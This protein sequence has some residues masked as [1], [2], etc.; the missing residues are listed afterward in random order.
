VGTPT[1]VRLRI[2]VIG[3]GIIGLACAEE[4]L[5][6]GHDVRVFDPD[7]ARGATYAAAGMLAPGG[8]AWFGEQDLLRL[9]LESLDRWRDY[10][11]RLGVD[12]RDTG[13]V[14]VGGDRGD[15][16]RLL[17]G[18]DLLVAHGV[19]VRPLGRSELRELEPTLG[20]RVVGGALLPG[21]H[22]VDPR[23]VAGELLR[24][25]GPALVRDTA[26]PRPGET[27]TGVVTGAGASYDAD[28]VVVATGHRLDA[29]VPQGGLVRPVRGEILRVRTTD[30]PTR[31]V[32]ALV[33]G[34]PVYL[35]PRAHGEVV[36][37]ATS[38]EHPGRTPD[39]P[40][41]RGVA[42]LIEAARR[43][44]PTLEDAELLEVTARDRPGSPD[45]GPLIG[46]TGVPGLL[47]ASGHFRGGV[48]LAP[49]TAEVVRAHVE[50]RAVTG[51]AAA[52]TPDRF[53]TH[54]PERTA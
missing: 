50:G 47:V 51:A 29:R 22:S 6:G 3:A 46:P 34:V 27:C 30:P 5:R 16:D 41:L 31:T 13:T 23:A 18:T 14:L 38:E 12:Y 28:A 17:S 45:N 9:G 53:R 32:R 54:V 33:D 37:G 4:L 48:L 8:E 42:Q 15:L 39:A 40:R 21:D 26:R 49:L 24:R 35:V 11:A 36:I 44:V 19:E 10:A 43:V 25:V 1:R 20:S 7:P 2:A 52:F